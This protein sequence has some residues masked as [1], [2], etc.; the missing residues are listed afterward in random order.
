MHITV[1]KVRITCKQKCDRNV[2]ELWIADTRCS[3]YRVEIIS[4][5]FKWLIVLRSAI[6][7]RDQTH[8]VLKKC[9]CR[10]LKCVQNARLA[11]RLISALLWFIVLNY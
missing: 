1:L 10:V 4:L 3:V 8:R 6:K 11:R 9:V 2:Y 7:S 5:A